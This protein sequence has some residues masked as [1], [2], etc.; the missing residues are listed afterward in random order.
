MRSSVVYTVF[1]HGNSSKSES[2]FSMMSRQSQTSLTVSIVLFPTLKSTVRNAFNFFNSSCPISSPTLYS[3]FLKKKK[4]TIVSNTKF[5]TKFENNHYKHSHLIFEEKKNRQPNIEEFFLRSV[6]ALG[7]SVHFEILNIY[8][9]SF[10]V[11]KL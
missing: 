11:T 10:F 4:T 3:V 7:L 5:S 1:R 9:F 6:K 8:I 2:L